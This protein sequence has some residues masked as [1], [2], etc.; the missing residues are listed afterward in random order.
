[1]ATRPTCGLAAAAPIPIVED[2]AQA[3]R[4]VHGRAV[5]AAP[6][7]RR[8]AS[9]REDARRLRRRRCRHDRRPEFAPPA[10]PARPRP[11][12]GQVRAR[13]GGNNARMSE[14]RRR[15]CAELAHLP[16]GGGA[17]APEATRNSWRRESGSSG[18]SPGP[19]TWHLY[20]LLHAD[21][22]RIA[23]A[24]GAGSRQ[25]STTRSR[26]PPGMVDVP[27]RVRT[28]T[29]VTDALAAT[30]LASDLPGA[31][32]RR[33]HHACPGRCTAC[34]PA[35]MSEPGRRQ[36]ASDPRR[37]SRTLADLPALGLGAGRAGRRPHREPRLP[38]RHAGGSRCSP[39]TT[40]P[41]SAS[42]RGSG[43]ASPHEFGPA[44]RRLAAHQARRRPRTTCSPMAT[45]RRRLTS[46]RW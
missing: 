29:A 32:R 33:R 14:I 39:R 3:R 2:A 25:A 22:D 41:S 16:L 4:P 11:A 35:R 44:I 28:A 46:T 30:C 40:S 45:G 26:P 6:P 18:S 31:R 36:P 21:R 24:R 43:R 37:R 9:I 10:P 38:R 1:M 20:V 7:P 42:V 13:L 19:S 17:A 15:C 23:R 27:H 8:T 5:G 12:R 34:S